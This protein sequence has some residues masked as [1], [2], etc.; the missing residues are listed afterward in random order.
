M[1]GEGVVFFAGD[2]VTAIRFYWLL[3]SDVLGTGAF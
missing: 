2:G 1:R 3:N